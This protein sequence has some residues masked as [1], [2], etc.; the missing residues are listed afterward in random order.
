MDKNDEK[1]R[2]RESIDFP[3]KGSI[4]MSQAVPRTITAW[5]SITI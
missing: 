4:E 3:W 5:T 1:G 2:E